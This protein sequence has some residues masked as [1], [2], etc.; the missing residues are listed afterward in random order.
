[1][2]INSITK[3]N[4]TRSKLK[5]QGKRCNT[6]KSM[7]NYRRK[8]MQEEIDVGNKYD[9]ILQSQQPSC[10]FKIFLMTFI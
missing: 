2:F 10:S 3:L 7:E 4:E 8:E 9:D 1:M 6:V 5:I